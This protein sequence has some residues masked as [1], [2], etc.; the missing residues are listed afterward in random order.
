M[1]RLWQL[2]VFSG[3]GLVLVLGAFMLVGQ[4]K[5]DLAEKKPPAVRP[6]PV[7][8]ARAEPGRLAIC[9]HYIGTIEPRVYADLSPRITGHLY[10]VTGD[11]GDTLKKGKVA[12][13]IDPRLPG[14]ERDAVAAELKGAK[15]ALRISE[16]IYKRRQKLIKKNAV[17][18]ED[19]DNARRQYELDLARVNRL[20]E[21]YAASAISFQYA[22]L[23]APFDGIII[24]RQSDPGDLIAPGTPVLRVEKPS[25][26]YKILVH[27]PQTTADRLVSG[28]AARLSFQEKQM[29]LE[30][31]RIHP[32]IRSGT[33]ATLEM[34][35]SQKPFALPS[36]STIDV[37]VIVNR[38][39][40][41]IIPLSCL[42]EQEDTHHVFAIDRKQKTARAVSVR[43]LGK[44]GDRALIEG[45]IPAGAELVSGS[46]S[47]L[48]Q[49]GDNAQIQ[50]LPP[51]GS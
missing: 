11:T 30:I 25:A 17:S 8:T 35:V 31:D 32:A 12:A 36:G 18:E 27:V 41:I 46:E 24:R 26:G 47:M 37:D 29:E 6:V 20:Q 2:S 21:E 42:L 7:H 43:I 14:R 28:N 48:I 44:S 51:E 3:L 45:D 5:A 33:L 40:G 10:S 49:L 4:R 19:V 1:K 38:P 39:E 22:R 16:K 13:V 9:E 23:K 15:K 50:P 34:R